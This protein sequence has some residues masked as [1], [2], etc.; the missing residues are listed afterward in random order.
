MVL[1]R[2]IPTDARAIAAI[3]VRSW[4]VAYEGIVPDAFLQSLCVENREAV[5]RE[6]LQEGTLEVHVV[7]ECDDV[8]GWMSV[9]SSRD[10]DAGPPTGELCAI[11]IAPEHWHQGAGR[12]LWDRAE[13]SLRVAG[14][15]EVTLWVLRDNC[16]ARRFYESLGFAPE[17]DQQKLIELGGL[18]LTEV[19][20]RYRLSG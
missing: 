1:R 12:L 2:A 8:I 15:A 19:R 3:H 18:G 6:C 14:F 9:S 11:Y 13:L 5:W 16:R 7:E 17:P 4:Q 10:P 20:L